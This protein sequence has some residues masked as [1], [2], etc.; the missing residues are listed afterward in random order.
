M[1]PGQTLAW[2]QGTYGPKPNTPIPSDADPGLSLL[3]GLPA[4]DVAVLKVSSHHGKL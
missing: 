4:G 2:L 3:G 1:N